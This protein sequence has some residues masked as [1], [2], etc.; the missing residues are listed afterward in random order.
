MNFSGQFKLAHFARLC[1][2]ARGIFDP[3]KEKN[4]YFLTTENSQNP[5]CDITSQKCI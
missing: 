1:V 5:K 4:I 2:R 3:K